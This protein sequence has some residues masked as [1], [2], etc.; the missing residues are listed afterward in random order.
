MEYHYTYSITYTD[1][2]NIY[3][4]VRTS[5]C[6]PESDVRYWGTPVTFKAWMEAHKAT[7]V[8]TI[9]AI[10]PTREEA[11]LAED[12][13]IEQQWAINKP[14]SLNANI[15]GAKFNV[16]GFNHSLKTRERISQSLKGRT[17]SEKARLLVAD[18]LAGS[19]V[20]VNPDGDIVEFRNAS[21]FAREHELH[22]Q[23]IVAC[24]RGKVSNHKKWLF[25]Y[26]DDTR[27]SYD[28]LEIQ[29]KLLNKYIGISPL[30]EVFRFFDIS[31][32]AKT[33]KIN[34][35]SISDVF[36]G[37]VKKP[38][39]W[40]F[41]DDSNLT[42]TEDQISE[43][44]EKQKEAAKPKYI[45]Y[46]PCGDIYT[47]SNIQSFAREHG[48]N[49]STISGCVRGRYKHSNNWYFF[50]YKEELL[51]RSYIEEKIKGINKYWNYVAVTPTGEVIEFSSIKKF[52]E[53]YGF[54]EGNVSSYI[55]GSKK[56]PKGWYFCYAF[57]YYENNAA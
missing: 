32:F 4:G 47:F 34:R 7:R 44:I 36:S 49:G 37:R 48:L 13:L 55:G 54:Q 22:H 31:D 29:Y 38:A 28:F 53:E 17:I 57:Q 9:L 14:L 15:R 8:K 56:S 46:S 26:S 50:F 2:P 39:G 5:L 24:A 42:F 6:L 21:D 20:G 30:G 18:A 51:N 40:F 41:V 33:H 16:L 12:E 3:Y 19:F 25:Y 1:A 43:L 52:S 11:E 35:N 23:A 27:L 10:Y 45:T